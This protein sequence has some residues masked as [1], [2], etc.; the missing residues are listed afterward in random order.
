MDYHFGGRTECSVEAVPEGTKLGVFAL[1][2]M[3]ELVV[4]RYRKI[5]FHI[6]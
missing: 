5:T 4:I 2:H 6:S 1:A 3:V